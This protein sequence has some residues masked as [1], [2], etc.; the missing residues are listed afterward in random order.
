MINLPAHTHTQNKPD[1]TTHTFTTPHGTWTITQTGSLIAAIIGKITLID[2]PGTH[3][4]LETA[5]DERIN[6]LLELFGAIPVAVVEAHIE[7]DETVVAF[8]PAAKPEEPPVLIR[9][10]KL[11]DKLVAVFRDQPKVSDLEREWATYEPKPRPPADRCTCVGECRNCRADKLGE[12]F[13]SW[14][15]FEPYLTGEIRAHLVDTQA[16]WHSPQWKAAIVDPF[17]TLCADVAKVMARYIRDHFDLDSLEKRDWTPPKDDP[18]SVD[19]FFTA[20]YHPVRVRVSDAYDPPGAW[21]STTRSNYG[22]HL[23]VDE[24]RRTIL[25]LARAARLPEWTHAPQAEPSG[26]QE[27]GWVRLT[28]P[29]DGLEMA[30]CPDRLNEIP[31]DAHSWADSV[32]DGVLKIRD[33]KIWWCFGYQPATLTAEPK[34]EPQ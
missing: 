9:L 23:S 29:A 27:S 30:A 8:D 17:N 19:E 33:S 6:A 34:E 18:T 11:D 28:L 31:H 1:A 14:A 5:T 32:S 26:S 7:D 15:E 21:L 3:I 2:G 22:A 24:V 20:R 13:V 16:D 4:R 12:T 10:R 25:A